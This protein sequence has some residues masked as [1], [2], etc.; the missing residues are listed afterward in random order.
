MIA[1][2]LK[3]SIVQV[4]LSSR[5]GKLIRAVGVRIIPIDCGQN[6]SKESCG[7]ILRE[8]ALFEQKIL[9]RVIGDNPETA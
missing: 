7:L 2:N 1:D 9:G 8:S 3:G 6:S 4:S 5:Q